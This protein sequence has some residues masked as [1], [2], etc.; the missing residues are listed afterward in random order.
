MDQMRGL[1]CW[2]R[3]VE[4]TENAFNKYMFVYD[5]RLHKAE[6][7]FVTSPTVTAPCQRSLKMIDFHLLCH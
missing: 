1:I 6:V 2:L 4:K 3:L 5:A 7:N